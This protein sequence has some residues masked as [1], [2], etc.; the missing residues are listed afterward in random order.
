MSQTLD[1]AIARF[2]KD[3]RAKLSNPAATGEPEDQLR[4]PLETLFADLA[5][6]AGA[7]RDSIAMVGESSLADLKTRPDYAITRGNALVGFLELKA[8]GKGGDPRRFKDAH[9]RGQ[10]DKLKAL[11]NLLYTDGN[12]FTLWQDGNLVASASL[13][14][15]IRSSGA[16]LRAPASLVSLAAT[17]LNWKPIAPT[18]PKLL[19]E[20]TARLCRLLRDEVAEQLGQ[21]SPALT[22]LATDWRML[23]FPEASDAQFADGYAQTITFALLM[24]RARGIRLG[25]GLDQVAK[26]LGKTDSLISTALRV[27]TENAE[28]QAVLT[29]SISTLTRVLDVV[30]WH[31]VSRDRPEAW[32]YFY[33]DFLE[34]YDPA[35]RRQTGSYYTPPEVVESMVRLVDEL[36]RDRF[37]Q[38]D[39]LAS[40]AVT[41]VDPCVGTG[42]FLLGALRS[43]AETV[44]ASE[45]EGAVP[46][47]IDAALQ[48]LMAFE[49]QLGPFVVA[50]MR[51][52]AECFDL[53][54]GAPS[55]PL[56]MYVTDTL[57]DPF[58]EETWLPAI[59]GP[60]A[61]S[62]RR[63]NAIK[64]DQ[65]IMVVIG[66]PPYKEKAKGRGN[67]IEN[68]RGTF[69][70]PL[71]AW[72]PPKAWGVGLHA[73]H[74]RNLYVYF[75]RW[76]TW[77]VFDHEPNPGV[78]VVCFITVAGFLNGPGFQKMRDYLRRETDEIWVID[79]SPEGHQPEVP[80]RI[81][82]GVQQ[83]VCIVLAS[84]S[85]KPDRDVPARVRFRS[86][87][88]G[89]RRE[90]FAALQG[91]TLEDGGWVDAPSG[92]RD[93]FLPASTGVWSTYPALED[94]FIY[95]GSGV[96]PG[97][98]WIIAPDAESL[99][100]R[101]KALQEA[102]PDRKE[103]LFQPHLVDGKPGDRHVQRVVPKGLPG[104]D[105][106]P[107]PAGKDPGGC[108]P[109]LRY[110]FRSFD[111][112]WILPD[113]RLINRPNPELWASHSA[114]QVY[115]TALERTA[116]SA[117]PGLTLT[118][119]I[120]DLD[121][122]NGRGGRAHPLWLD[123]QA[124]V[125]NIPPGLPMELG[126]RYGQAVS[127]EDLVAYLA[128][129]TAHPAYTARF[130]A[131]LKRPGLRVPL[132][133][134]AAL[135]QET[136]ALGREVI[137]LHT[138]GERFAAGRPAGAPRVAQG[139][140]IPA[141][142]A[143]P[144]QGPLPDALDYDATRQRLHLGAGFIDGVPPQVWA[145]EVSGKPVL[146]HWF[147]YR[148][149]NR[150]R[151]LIGDKR[152]PSPLCDLQ[153]EHWLSEYTSDLL[154][155]LHVLCGLVQLEP[156]QAALLERICAGSIITRE[157]LAAAGAFALPEGHP[158]KPTEVTRHLPDSHRALF[159]V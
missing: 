106:R 16:K 61:E 56:R 67:W 89:R 18:S 3:A 109:P 121:H 98:T 81:F 80:T 45:G 6:L 60:I 79:C 126:R 112:Q 63:A 50:Q 9:D 15:D 14:G 130:Q 28:N 43:I 143:I 55:Q 110:A 57:G 113:N 119:L 71:E 40:K 73:K 69:P 25:N 31:K 22:A 133:A 107:L 86:L 84:R 117:G 116:P 30:D 33:E 62:R 104:Y 65:P 120:P 8:P 150:E 141:T 140:H 101:W 157:E 32:L 54:Q 124:Q 90:K 102:P 137:W 20:M 34:V 108:P 125:P 115:L 46:A 41:L 118:G 97:R 5:E 127:P 92:W 21:Q 85:H 93:P 4:A 75:W 139:P 58:V 59:L 136:V 38:T 95:N 36:L 39:G 128:A 37:W 96:M 145:Y 12:D 142:G 1:E 134:D 156:R 146:R 87:P 83:P 154:D 24:A 49:L 131:D 151:P 74:L 7:V 105:P 11:P 82:E 152:P 149:V 42:T 68:G 17:F 99:K 76:A 132:T 103:L 2:G 44:R 144:H 70:A 29:T 158:R 52:L 138:F 153:P 77:K 100:R 155:L 64:K 114:R 53:T 129:L 23:L 135:F 19:A 88:E 147:S 13:E 27:L 159:E 10:W 111:R 35:L 123:A 148:R 78:G 47:R 48:R 51:V 26:H 94:F 122:Y 72:Q 91:L 66:N